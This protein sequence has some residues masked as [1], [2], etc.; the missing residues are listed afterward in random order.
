MRRARS[1]ASDERE[2]SEGQPTD[3]PPRRSPTPKMRSDET[4][5][6]PAGLTASCPGRRQRL[7]VSVIPS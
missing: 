7:R 4:S 3:S 1:A 6:P 5:L 2:Q